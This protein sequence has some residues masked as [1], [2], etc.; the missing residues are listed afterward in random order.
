MLEDL[1][2][3]PQSY[4]LLTA[5]DRSQSRTVGH[6]PELRYQ[7]RAA[8]LIAFVLCSSA[9]S[10]GTG[11]PSQQSIRRSQA[12]KVRN[13]FVV[14]LQLFT[15]WRV[16]S[17]LTSQFENSTSTLGGY[18]SFGTRNGKSRQICSEQTWFPRSICRCAH[19]E[20]PY[21]ES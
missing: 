7:P 3:H 11:C 6:T 1:R 16:L 5:I 12:I 4:C 8:Q 19:S 14:C 18:L 13:S 20:K 21:R 17:E 9:N 10:R 2:S 15:G